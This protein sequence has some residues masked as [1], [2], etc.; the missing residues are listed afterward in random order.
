MTSPQIPVSRY[1]GARINRSPG[2]LFG[3]PVLRRS[4]LEQFDPLLCRQMKAA[5]GGYNSSLQ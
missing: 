2:A 5:I 3:H 1:M 4:V